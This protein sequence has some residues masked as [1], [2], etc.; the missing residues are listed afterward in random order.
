MVKTFNHDMLCVSF[1]YEKG[2]LRREEGL[3]LACVGVH[4]NEASGDDMDESYEQQRCQ[5]VVVSL[6]GEK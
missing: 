1:V 3:W 6:L 5:Y 4:A 2:C